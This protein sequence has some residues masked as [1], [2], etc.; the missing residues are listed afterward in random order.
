MCH[1]SANAVIP[2]VSHI[3]TKNERETYNETGTGNTFQKLTAFS[4]DT[5]AAIL[6]ATTHGTH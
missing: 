3:P 6:Q 2:V 1:K 4:K 5:G